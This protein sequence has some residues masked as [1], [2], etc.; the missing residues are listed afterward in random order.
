M[1]GRKKMGILLAV[2]STVLILAGGREYMTG[3]Q[4]SLW[5]KSVTDVREVTSQGAHAFEVYIT[6]DMEMLHGITLNL[7]QRYS[8]DEEAIMAKLNAFGETGANYSVVDLD[9]G[10]LYSKQGGTNIEIAQLSDEQLA[11]YEGFSGSGIEEPYLSEDTGQRMMGYYECFQFMDGARGLLKKEQLLSSIAEEFSLSFYNNAGFSYVVNS[12]GDI[13]IRSEHR[14]SNRTFRN[15]FDVI[16]LEENSVDISESF[17]NALTEGKTGVARFFYRSEEYVYAYVPIEI[18]NGWYLITIIPNRVIMTQADQV[19]KS[20]QIFIFLVGASMIVFA[21]FMLLLWRSHKDIMEVEQE[22]KYREQLFGILTNNTDDVYA[23]FTTGDYEVEYISP[24]IERVLGIPLEEVKADFTVLWRERREEEQMVGRQEIRRME[25]GSSI[26]SEGER[27]HRTTGEH[28]WFTETLYKVIIDDTEKLIVSF[29]DKTLDKQRE[30]ALEQALE[31]AEVAN[32]S[33]SAFLSN[34][35]HDIRTPMNAVVGLCTLLQR[36]ADDAEKV[37]DHTRKI[38]A[39]S[40]H[41]LGLINDVLDMSKIES[42]KTTLNISEISLAEIVEE[43]GT[44]IRPQA[45]ARRQT[46]AI[47]VYDVKVEHLLGDKLRI[48]Q[49]LINILS[50]SVKYTK[51]GGCIEMIIRQMPQDT[52]NYVNLQFTIQ[53]NGIGMSQKYIDT[54]FQPFTREINSTTNRIQGTGLGMAI[55]KNLV[56]LM[57]GT[58][59]VESEPG[60]GTAFHVNLELRMQDQGVDKEFWKKYGVT[61]TLIVDDEEDVCTSVAGAMRSAGVAAEFAVRGLDAVKMV[62]QAHEEGNDFDFVLIDW[63]MPDMGGVET[64]RRIREIISS[65]TLIMVLTAY[66]WSEIEEEAVSAGIDGFLPKPFFLTNFKQ[67]VE[68]LREKKEIIPKKEPS[69]GSLS[70]KHILAAEDNELNSEILVELLDMAGATCEMAENGQI[71]LEKFQQSQP[72]QYDLI[73][74]DV[75]MPVMNGYEATRAIRACDHPLAKTIPIIAM[76]ANAFAED[77]KN[78]LDAGM[79]AH[80]AKP[81]NLELLGN[82]VAEIFEK[83]D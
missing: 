55:T 72:G 26:V 22:V 19:L 33:K 3:V 37:R 38:T 35:S 51:P 68:R 28:L 39:S 57:G 24:N 77:I 79:D 52:K 64:A 76:T 73:L 63:K 71:A 36:D 83:R 58:I 69:S 14:N 46:F 81:V 8:W 34:M 70:G 80:V 13:L 53:D 42:G 40:Q 62:E 17:R 27:V 45:K 60:K 16:N 7:E 66:D 4:E 32:Q 18:T 47:S 10:V 30:Q 48:N 65:D 29:F 5:M 78:A 75:Q 23:M 2:L 43:L 61:H 67:T 11:G 9:N 54:I 50:N 12:S 74:M 15:V 31:I 25:P 44:I 49:I 82:V 20:S 59:T 21:S 1:T 56:D 6:K 41:L